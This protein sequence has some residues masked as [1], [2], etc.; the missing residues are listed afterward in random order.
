MAVTLHFTSAGKRAATT[1]NFVPVIC[2]ER[3]HV[4]Q[5]VARPHGEQGRA[6]AWAGA[7]AYFVFVPVAAVPTH[8]AKLLPGPFKSFSAGQMADGTAYVFFFEGAH[9]F[10]YLHVIYCA[11]ISLLAAH[12]RVLHATT[13]TTAPRIHNRRGGGF[14]TRG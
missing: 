3:I 9:L 13:R 14:G 7:P 11:A 12:Y 5:T 10:I 1:D 2:V 8:T 4:M 6:P